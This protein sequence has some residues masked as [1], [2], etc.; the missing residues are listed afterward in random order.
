MTLRS[1]ALPATF[2]SAYT[3]LCGVSVSRVRWER[4]VAARSVDNARISF[5]A[6]R[7]IGRGGIATN[8]LGLYAVAY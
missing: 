4:T 3:V 7:F 5:H 2:Y 1:T 6:R 8:V